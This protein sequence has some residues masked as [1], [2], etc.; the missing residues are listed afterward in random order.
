LALEILLY[1]AAAAS[2]EAVKRYVSLYLTRLRQIRC[3]LDGVALKRLGL[4][5]GPD[6]GRVMDRLLAARLDGEISSDDE[7][8]ALAAELIAPKYEATEL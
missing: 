7:E 4:L 2:Q 6:F 5:P 3:G 8:R 1:L